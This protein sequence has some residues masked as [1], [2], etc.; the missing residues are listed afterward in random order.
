ME[1]NLV[2]F[3]LTVFLGE[4]IDLGLMFFFFKMCGGLYGFHIF[5][6]MCFSFFCW[7]SKGGIDIRFQL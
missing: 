5:N 4:C 1:W 2:F 7:I 6:M 3:S